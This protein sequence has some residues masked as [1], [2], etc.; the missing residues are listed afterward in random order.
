MLLAAA[1]VLLGAWWAGG[2]TVGPPLLTAAAAAGLTTFANVDNDRHDV[3]ID[4]VAHPERPLV[5]GT[6]T[7]GAA[8]RLA[9]VA[10][11][12]GLGLAAAARPAL[13]AAAAAVLALMA[14]YNRAVSRSG[15][16]GNLVVAALA[17]LPF[18][19]GAWSVG[20]PAAGLGITAL[21]VP[22]HLAREVAKDIDDS[23]GDVLARRTVPV[24]Y[25]AGAARALFAGAL[26][27]FWAA[28]A[29]FAGRHAHL[30]WLLLPAVGLTLAGAW[31]VLH[32]RRGAPALLKAAMVAAMASLLAGHSG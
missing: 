20:R 30:R 19:F 14:L 8:A 12:A 24:A 9:L 1:G 21:A 6:V 23:A 26:V 17:S 18:L 11:I 5:R 3:A 31:R 7:A 16:P 10:A 4:A 27:A 2:D 25:G 15:L 13:G 29:A 28:L 22:L 32:G